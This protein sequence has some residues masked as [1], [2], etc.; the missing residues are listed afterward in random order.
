MINN[1]VYM[2]LT[3]GV[4]ENY[5]Y[6]INENQVSLLD[7]WLSSFLSPEILTYLDF[8]YSHYQQ[9]A[10]SMPDANM[11]LLTVEFQ[12]DENSLKYVRKVQSIADILSLT[13]GLMGILFALINITLR[14]I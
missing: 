13:G 5:Y 3:P 14:P 9:G 2:T 12:L 6:K 8:R 4:S 10:Y 1:D 11:P 7:T